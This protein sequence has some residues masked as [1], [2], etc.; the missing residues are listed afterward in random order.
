MTGFLPIDDPSRVAE[1][2]RLA[3][4][5]AREEGLDAQRIGDAGLAA[6]EMATNLWKHAK[7]GELQMSRLADVAAPGVDVLAIDR[8]PGIASIEDCLRDGYSSTGTNGTGL[9]AISRCAQVFDAYSQPARGT[10][11]LARIGASE[12]VT[13]WNLESYPGLKFRHPA[14]IAGTL[15]RDATRSRDDVCVIVARHC[16]E[17]AL[18]GAGIA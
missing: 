10:V 1:A 8:G 5:V 16:M 4:T 2:R 12:A 18:H 13:S 11:M 3:M 6:T 7:G 17:Q 14:V 9:G 15:Y